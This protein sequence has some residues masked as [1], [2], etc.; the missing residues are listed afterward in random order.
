MS[1][2][3]ESAGPLAAEIPIVLVVLSDVPPSQN[4][5]GDQEFHLPKNA[6]QQM[7]N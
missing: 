7:D 6:I 3:D 2:T 4:V 1:A 5:Q